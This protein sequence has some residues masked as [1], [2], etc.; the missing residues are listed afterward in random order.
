MTRILYR[1]IIVVARN[2]AAHSLIDTPALQSA[3]GKIDRLTT[4]LTYMD[5]LDAIKNK[6]IARSA[7]SYTQSASN[8]RIEHL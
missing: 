2:L 4:G 5:T 8:C 1:L 7:S 3:G 6:Q